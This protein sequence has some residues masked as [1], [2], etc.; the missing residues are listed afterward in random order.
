MKNALTISKPSI[1]FW[2]FIFTSGFSAPSM[3]VFRFKEENEFPE[4]SSSAR[5]GACLVTCEQVSG[6]FIVHK[7]PEVNMQQQQC[8]NCRFTETPLDQL[9]YATH[10]MRFAVYT[11]T[12]TLEH[13]EGSIPAFI[14]A[15][16]S[17]IFDEYTEAFKRFV[18]SQGIDYSLIAGGE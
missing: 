18:E 1:K 2:A 11:L 3:R 12:R 5:T 6:F 17:F 7:S 9:N 8:S 13:E 16:L 4:I 14:P 10:K 15:G